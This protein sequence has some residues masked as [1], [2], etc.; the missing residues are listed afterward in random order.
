M[1]SFI[2]FQMVYPVVCISEMNIQKKGKYWKEILV[3]FLL[4]MQRQK[5]SYL[6]Y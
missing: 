5:F 1:K 6:I 4:N 3:A 2:L